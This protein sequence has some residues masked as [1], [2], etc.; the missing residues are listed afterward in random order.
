MK[1]Q[2][3]Y[4]VLGV[5]R[6]A[7]KEEI[8]KAYRKLAR[9]FHPDVNKEKDAE[10]RFKKIS[11]A[12]EVLKDPGKRKLYDQLGQNWQAGQDFKPPPGW[13]DIFGGFQNSGTGGTRGRRTQTFSMGSGGD[14][15]GFSD[16]FQALFG[17]SFTGFGEGGQSASGRTT[18]NASSSQQ[19]KTSKPVDVYVTLEEV[20]SNAKKSVNLK[21]TTHNPFGQKDVSNKLVS[22]TI[23]EGTTDGKLIRLKS[24]PGSKDPEVVL[25]LRLAKHPHFQVQGTN[26]KGYIHITPWEAALGTKV[27]CQTLSGSVN[28]TIPKGTSSGKQLRLKG[29]GLSEKGGIKGDLL[30]E[31]KIV[32]PE[33]LSTK[34][35]ELFEELA[36]SSSFTPR[37]Q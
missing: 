30:L 16:F 25:R 33:I 24:K 20:A 17:G 2:D 29:H 11:E 19:N 23:P 4:E 27:P 18:R 35:R 36:K 37:R 8:S 15:S 5:N 6:T 14:T 34:E 1:F 12:H 26:I 3:Y 31:V 10:D 13:E 28:I 22:F 21:F 32:V 7:T 9:K